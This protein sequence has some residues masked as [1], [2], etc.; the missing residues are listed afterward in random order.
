MREEGSRRPRWSTRQGSS[1]AGVISHSQ[2]ED[3]STFQISE[4]SG[5]QFTSLNL[6]ISRKYG[7][8]LFMQSE[9][10]GT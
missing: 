4:L 1:E 6:R 2:N 7:F 8:A 5:L 10:K 3:F 9:F